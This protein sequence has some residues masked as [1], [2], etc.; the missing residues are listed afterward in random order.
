MTKFA[1]IFR[2]LTLALGISFGLCGIAGA[3]NGIL[4]GYGCTSV[5]TKLAIT[6]TRESS[7][8][9]RLNRRPISCANCAAANRNNCLRKATRFRPRRRS[10]SRFWLARQRGRIGLVTVLRSF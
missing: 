5:R 10:I 1:S 7:P 2:Q 9:G 8:A 6:A 3:H 4:D